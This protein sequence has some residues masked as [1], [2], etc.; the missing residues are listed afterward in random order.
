MTPTERLHYDDPLLLRFTAR[1]AA[2]AAHPFAPGSQVPPRPG[3]SLAVVLDRTAFYPESGG[4]M[5]D[6]GALSGASV[7]DVQVDAAGVVHH[8][9]EPGAPLPAVG[10]EV[11]GTIDKARRRA[12]MAL[13]TGQHMLSR[14]LVNVAGAAT[15]SSRLGETACTL[16]TDRETLDDRAVAEAEAMVNALIDDDVAVRAYF[17]AETELAA[18]DL[19]AAPKVKGAI[20]VI[21]VGDFDLCPCGGTHCTRTAQVGLLR[22]SGTE[23]YKGKVR[24][25]FSAGPRARK[26]LWA[27]AEL[28]RDLG[29][30]LT[31]GPQ[32][33]PSAIERL[34][35]EMTGAR[36]A[37]GRVRGHLAEALAAEI[38]LRS[39][40]GASGPFI[41]VLED[42]SPELLRAVAGR[43]TVAPE[44]V[45]MLAGRTPEGLSVLVARG[46]ESRFDC[47]AFLKKAAEHGR[48]RGGGRPSLAEGRLPGEA[49]WEEVVAAV[50]GDD[51]F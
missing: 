44:A 27:D 32:D 15:V 30:D 26:E 20:R 1:V 41:A 6:R 9:L 49:T 47:G 3:G 38:V 29:R 12:H 25:F 24:L 36:E 46:S 13:H 14:A 48:G 5:A 37:L 35:R 39:T 40:P 11:T 33:L 34:R 50:L 51:D 17:P 31:C 2:H 10:T 43:L 7:V 42:A 16:D 45:A 4:Q 22:V 8:L 18:L 28:L 21:A 23:R 19:R